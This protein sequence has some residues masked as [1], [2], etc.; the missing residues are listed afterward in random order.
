MDPTPTPAPQDRQTGAIAKFT[1]EFDLGLLL[2]LSRKSLIWVLLFF[3]LSFMTA[4][5]Y[6]RYTQ[7]VFEASSVL[8]IRS[9]N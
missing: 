6:L 5:L 4:F 7:Q 3:V 9:S 8:Q 2:Y 1:N